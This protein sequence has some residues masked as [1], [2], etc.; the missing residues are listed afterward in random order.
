[1]TIWQRITNLAGALG[2]GTA[3]GAPAAA[4]ATPMLAADA[5][6]SVAFTTAV[7]AL[8]AK[9]AK[10][11]GVVSPIEV[12]AF[13]Q[14]FKSPPEE[15]ARVRQVFELAQRDI[16]GFEVYAR[17][18]SSI[19]GNDQRRLRDVLECLFHIASAD[20]ALHPG[21]DAFLKTV[22]T[23]F[24]FSDSTY[25]HV[26]AQFVEDPAAPYSVLGLDPSTSD[27]ALKLRHRK[28]VRENHPDILQGRGLP[29]ETV[30]IANRKLAAINAAFETIARERGL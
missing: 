22:A 30:E 6:N 19:L 11:D 10:A 20:R 14:V 7:I 3:C 15:A 12:E 4:A 13:H 26:R 28:L 25:R 2:D 9:M 23:C 17:Q 5:S 1:M 24:G 21:E 18:I 8:G 16:A 27:E 29:P